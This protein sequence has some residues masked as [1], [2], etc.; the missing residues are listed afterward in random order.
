MRRV[1][2]ERRGDVL[3]WRGHRW[4]DQRWNQHVEEWALARV[5]VLR[6]VVGAL[7]IVRAWRNAHGT[8]QVAVPWRGR[9]EGWQAVEGEV[10]LCRAATELEVANRCFKVCWQRAGGKHV[11]KGVLGVGRR[12]DGVA[13]D[14]F[15]R[16]QHHAD[17][18]VAAQQHLLHWGVGAGDCAKRLRC[19]GDRRRH[20]ASATL[21]QR[22]LAER[23]VDLAEVVM[24]E[25]H[26]RAG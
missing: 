19:A 6:I 20:G 4:V 11:N 10:H 8:Q 18:L 16:L 26:A 23:T 17:R 2:H 12:H 9:R 5:A 24:Q 25:D 14:L 7:H 1:L 13:V 21:R 15:A 22:P 3:P